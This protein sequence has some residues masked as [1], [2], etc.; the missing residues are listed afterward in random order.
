ML[1]ELITGYQDHDCSVEISGQKG[2]CQLEPNL[3]RPRGVSFAKPHSRPSQRSIQNIDRVDARSRCTPPRHPPALQ[4]WIITTYIHPNRKGTYVHNNTEWNAIREKWCDI[5]STLQRSMTWMKHWYC[6]HGY[7]S[8]HQFCSNPSVHLFR[9]QLYRA[10][11]SSNRCLF[12][13]YCVCTIQV[14][15]RCLSTESM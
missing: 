1:I 5:Y 14:P 13:R 3:K 9:W 6:M 7:R 11:L 15:T 2:G 12:T 10:S 8:P 4:T